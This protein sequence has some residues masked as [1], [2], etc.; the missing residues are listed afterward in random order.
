MA[1]SGASALTAT[2][3]L[4]AMDVSR[5]WPARRRMLSMVGQLGGRLGALMW[6]DARLSLP[7]APGA[8]VPTRSAFGSVDE[9]RRARIA[10]IAGPVPAGAHPA[11]VSPGQNDKSSVAAH[12]QAMAEQ[13]A[14]ERRVSGGAARIPGGWT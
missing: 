13:V 8:H 7:S 12:Y 3:P 10:T 4:P 9:R 11:R 14:R 6:G 2:R 1:T 5:P